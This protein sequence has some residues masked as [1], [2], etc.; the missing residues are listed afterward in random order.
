MKDNI[1]IGVFG[2]SILAGVIMM[3]YSFLLWR[4]DFSLFGLNNSGLYFLYGIGAVIFPILLYIWGYTIGLVASV[5]SL[6]ILGA[7]F[8]FGVL[9]DKN[10]EHE[11]SLALVVYCLFALGLGL[12]SMYLG[13]KSAHDAREFNIQANADFDLRPVVCASCDQYLGQAQSYK[14]PCPRCGSNR[15][16]IE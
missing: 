8:I 3:I 13:S 4:F 6:V 16:Q 11:V 9:L 2:F 10:N 5:G 12:V 14:S 15:Y 7:V 1:R